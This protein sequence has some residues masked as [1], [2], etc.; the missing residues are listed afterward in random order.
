MV[1]GTLTLK[2][3]NPA[4]TGNATKFTTEISAGD[5]IVATVGGVPYT[6][7]VKTI[8][9]D[10]VL[11]L[12]SNYTGPDQ[13]GVTW[14]A[15]PRAALNLVTADLVAQVTQALR[16]LNYDKTNWQQIFSGNGN[17]TVRLPD[18]TTW[19][20]PAW[21]GIAGLI[22]NKFDKTGGRID[23][24]IDSTGTILGHYN[25]I[26]ERDVGR[27]EQNSTVAG[28]LL[29]SRMESRGGFSDP[30]GAY[31]S[32]YTE[33]WVGYEHRAII[34]LDG[35]GRNSY[36]I[37]RNDGSFDSNTYR[38]LRG[39]IVFWTGIQ[40]GFLQLSVDGALRG[41]NFFDSDINKKEDIQ[42]VNPGSAAEVIRQIHPV[43][44]KFKDTKYD[45]GTVEGKRYSFG[46]IA[47]E[48]E[49]IIP[50]AVNTLSDGS[51]SLDPLAVL[52]LLLAANKELVERVDRLETQLKQL[53][54]RE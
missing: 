38:G 37:C 9:S 48:I 13:S 27:P 32:L 40:P 25:V 47:Q 42:E 36:W 26:S 52:G 31:V 28:G 10:T 29:I 19:S 51:K 5:F 11:T 6:L 45:G 54:T 30:A 23:G 53:A 1:T 50:D 24:S 22:S 3:N 34:S 49:Q 4:V 44:Y 7:P 14:S 46:V 20:G 43:S 35:F 2:Y 41:I 17:V 12:V 18:N 33:E 8:D 39:R 15:V 16:G 21:N